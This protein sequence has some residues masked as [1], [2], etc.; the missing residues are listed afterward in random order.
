MDSFTRIIQEET[1]KCVGVWSRANCQCCKGKGYWDN[2]IQRY[3]CGYCDGCTVVAVS[4]EDY[5]M[6]LLLDAQRWQRS[7]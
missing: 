3:L 4:P 7:N 1:Q 6:L 5:E 2:G